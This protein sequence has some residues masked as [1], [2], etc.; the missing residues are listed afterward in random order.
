MREPPWNKAGTA[1]LGGG[2][3]TH[4]VALD[5]RGGLGAAHALDRVAADRDQFVADL[6]QPDQLGAA[7]GRDL[8]DGRSGCVLRTARA[9]KTLVV[10]VLVWRGGTYLVQNDPEFGRA[11]GHGS[12]DVLRL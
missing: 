8:G 9:V 4:R 12:V 3:G 7:A 6:G 5:G 11:D 10:M 2:D 1:L